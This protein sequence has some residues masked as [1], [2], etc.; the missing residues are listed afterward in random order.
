MIVGITIISIL[1]TFFMSVWSSNRF[2]KDIFTKEQSEMQQNYT[3][4]LVKDVNHHFEQLLQDLSNSTQQLSIVLTDE[5]GVKKEVERL[6]EQNSLLNGVIIMN[7]EGL[8]LVSS[9]PSTILDEFLKTQ[10]N[11][12]NVVTQSFSVNQLLKINKEQQVIF[13]AYPIRSDKDEYIGLIGATVNL[14]AQS[15]LGDQYDE[16]KA[17]HIVDTDG[18]IVFDG[19]KKIRHSVNTEEMIIT[20]G[21][22]PLTDW[23]LIVQQPLVKEKA[24]VKMMLENIILTMAP[25]LLIAFVVVMWMAKKVAQ[26]MQQLSIGVEESIKANSTQGLKEM[27]DWYF[28]AHH[29]KNLLVSNL[30]VLQNQIVTLKDQVALD[31]LTGIKNRRTID[32]VLSEW[33]FKKVPHAIILVDLDYF[34]NINDTYGH[35][36]GDEVL[37]VFAKNMQEVVDKN[38]LCSRYGGEEFLILL[39][40]V[41][42]EKALEIVGALRAKQA[43]TNNLS[44]CPVTFSAGVTVCSE[45]SKTPEQLIN[46]ADNALY[47]AKQAGRNCT[48]VAI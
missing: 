1:S 26:P 4:Q 12:E 30:T 22:I 9:I 35:T 19:N 45:M 37:K 40:Y 46:I 20:N 39:P 8:P 5:D 7:K 3:N 23:Q 2:Y 10:W 18:E 43:F 41:T 15:I 16:E 25:F 21:I 6:K 38:G 47:K 32:T 36:V 42:L 14:T 17:I 11:F 31:P 24:S 33:V 44:G 48:K 29:L 34:K 27:D 28:E 13:I